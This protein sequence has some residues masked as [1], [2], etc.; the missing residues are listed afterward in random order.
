MKV[1]LCMNKSVSYIAVYA[2]YTRYFKTSA[3]QCIGL[4]C[5]HCIDKLTS[6][7]TAMHFF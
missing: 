4:L 2:I 6:V 7:Y 5:L 3:H 1:L